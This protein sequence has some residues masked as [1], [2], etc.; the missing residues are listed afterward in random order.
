[1]MNYIMSPDM[2]NYIMSL[3][4]DSQEFASLLSKLSVCRQSEREA[5]DLSD[6]ETYDFI[7]QAPV[8]A[9]AAAAA[10]IARRGTRR[11]AERGKIS[12]SLWNP[13]HPP[14]APPQ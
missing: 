9:A 12:V 13:D 3:D 7:F 1:M 10:A 8:A 2:M 14:P 11:N 5:K 6:K 4:V